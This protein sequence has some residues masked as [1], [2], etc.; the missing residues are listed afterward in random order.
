MKTRVLL[1]ASA[2]GL[3]MSVSAAAADLASDAKAFGARESVSSPDLSTDGSSVIYLTPG[4]GRKD[5]AVVG[6]LDT[7]QFHTVV[8][9]DGQ[10]ESLTWCHFG[11]ASRA[12]CRFGGFVPWQG[13]TGNGEP[14]YFSRLLALDLDGSHPKLMGQP[15]TAHDEWIR[16]TDGQI[17]D[18]LDSNGQV[19]VN[20]LYMPETDTVGKLVY[21]KKKGWGLDK[22]DVSSLR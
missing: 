5:V 4:P 18:W 1:L 15:E 16:Q 11:S 10:P 14:V 17:I 3:S 19:L 9:A 21:N 13:S 8:S 2:I 12:V 6:N 7:G 22:V 20:R